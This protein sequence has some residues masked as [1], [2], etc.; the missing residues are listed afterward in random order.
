[1]N[2]NP[3][4]EDDLRNQVKLRAKGLEPFYETPSVLN[5]RK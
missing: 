4:Q 1:M 3:T 5:N 2:S